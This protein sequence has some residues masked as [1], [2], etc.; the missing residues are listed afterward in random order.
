MK[1]KQTALYPE[2]MGQPGM[3]AEV[4]PNYMGK[5]NTTAPQAAPQHTSK[6]K[7]TFNKPSKHYE[8][9]QSSL[10]GGI[11]GPPETSASR[12]GKRMVAFNPATGT[13]TSERPF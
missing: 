5:E 3:R 2:G 4:V 10:Q 11:F 13:Y 8:L 1:A 6:P 12:S 7:A 9:G